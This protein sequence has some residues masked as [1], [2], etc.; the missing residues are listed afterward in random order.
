MVGLAHVGH[1]CYIW[2]RGDL[3]MA[4]LQCVH[5]FKAEFLAEGPHFLVNLRSC[6]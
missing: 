4:H 2:P 1:V 5:A 3:C 6:Q